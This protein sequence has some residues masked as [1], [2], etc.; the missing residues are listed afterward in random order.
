M[1]AVLFSA[2]S[3]VWPWYAIWG[4]APAALLPGWWLSRFVFAVSLVMPFTLAA[5]WSEP[6]PHHMEFAALIVYATACLWT[7]ATADRARRS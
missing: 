5:W 3:H 2:V 7:F 4:L 6:F 1:A